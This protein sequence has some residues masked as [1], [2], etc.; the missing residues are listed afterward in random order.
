MDPWNVV[1]V[2]CCNNV[3][4]AVKSIQL[5]QHWP[6]FYHP[7]QWPLDVAGCNGRFPGA[8]PD[9]SE[10]GNVTAQPFFKAFGLRLP[11]LDLSGWVFF[12]KSF[13]EVF[14]IHVL[15]TGT[16]FG[17][18]I[19]THVVL[20]QCD[21]C[22]GPVLWM[23][24][25]GYVSAAPCCLGRRSSPSGAHM[26]GCKEFET[27]VR[28]FLSL[29][30]RVRS[31]N[32][33]PASQRALPFWRMQRYV[34]HAA[35]WPLAKFP[36]SGHTQQREDP[37]F[38][39][40][41]CLFLGCFHICCF[42]TYNVERSSTA[43]CSPT[44]WWKTFCSLYPWCVEC[45]SGQEKSAEWFVAKVAV[46]RWIVDSLVFPWLLYKP[47]YLCTP[48]GSHGSCFASRAIL[49]L[50]TH[51]WTEQAKESYVCCHLKNVLCWNLESGPL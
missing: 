15:I 29:K 24:I 47:P 41:S 5:L 2:F 12:V 8:W 3:S 30:T 19:H 10:S 40:L 17:V 13:C 18:C 14:L 22:P 35:N 44:Y 36:Y 49:W 31:T 38:F 23:S 26:H 32:I 16:F 42:F 34:C 28:L 51:H 39:C 20:A 25:K 6:C 45:L 7:L 48:W 33:T 27:S 1:H 46:H 9:L 21:F 50:R 11:T 4:L 37:T 43:E